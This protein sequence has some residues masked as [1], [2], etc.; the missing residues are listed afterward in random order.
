MESKYLSDI[1]SDLLNEAIIFAQRY[2]QVLNTN[3]LI[4]SNEISQLLSGFVNNISEK[5]YFIAI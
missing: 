4:Y 1:M 5:M 2:F 3:L